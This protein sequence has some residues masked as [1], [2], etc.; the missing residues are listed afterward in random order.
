MATFTEKRYQL[1]KNAQERI[2]VLSLWPMKSVD[3]ESLS[4]KTLEGE[5]FILAWLKGAAVK[6]YSSSLRAGCMT[7]M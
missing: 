3:E 1:E 6:E 2:S 4:W 5:L 7:H